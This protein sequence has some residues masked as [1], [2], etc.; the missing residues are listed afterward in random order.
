MKNAAGRAWSWIENHAWDIVDVIH[1]IGNYVAGA[2][3]LCAALFL[4]SPLGAVCG[5]VTLG[6]SAVSLITGTAL[7]AGGRLSRTGLLLDAVGALLS[8]TGSVFQGAANAARGLGMTDEAVA[9]LRL[10]QAHYAGSVTGI[11]RTLSAGWSV[12]KTA[13]W[14]A[15]A[16]GLSF[17]SWMLSASGFGFSLVS[18]QR[19]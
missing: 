9:G 1:K 16:E 12:A 18:V 4:G 7:Y 10:L 19:Q 8:G 14:Y 13:G 5:G 2:A 11:A 15:V 17:V 3:G 6:A